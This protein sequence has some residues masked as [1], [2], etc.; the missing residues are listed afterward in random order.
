MSKDKTYRKK[1]KR[2]QIASFGFLTHVKAAV[3]A[4]LLFVSLPAQSQIDFNKWADVLIAASDTSSNV[5]TALR[6]LEHYVID[7]K[8]VEEIEDRLE[9]VKKEYKILKLET[10]I[11]RQTRRRDRQRE[12]TL[13]RKEKFIKQQKKEP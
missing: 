10:K 6:I 8:E 12:K 7:S 4:V 11:E 5:G 1:E 3:L 2:S 9:I 13:R